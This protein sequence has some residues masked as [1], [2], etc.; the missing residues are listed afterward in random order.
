MTLEAPLSLPFRDMLAHPAIGTAH[1]AVKDTAVKYTRCLSVCLSVCL[2][3]ISPIIHADVRIR[4]EF[5]SI[6][7]RVFHS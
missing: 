6:Y 1:T 7:R 3:V 4:D 2:P 5:V